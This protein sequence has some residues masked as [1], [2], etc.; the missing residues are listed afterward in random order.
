VDRTQHVELE[1]DVAVALFGTEGLGEAALARAR[2]EMQAME[3]LGD[4][5]HLVTV[6]DTG[7]ADGSPYIVS[8]YMPGGDVQRLLAASEGGRLEVGR[9]ISIG[10]DVCRALEHAHAC[11]IIHRDLK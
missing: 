1:T 3:K 6:H 5:P 4:H 10:I 7:E 2:R 11:G 8:R 9:A